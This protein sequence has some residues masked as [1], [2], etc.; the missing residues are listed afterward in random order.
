MGSHKNSEVIVPNYIMQI[1]L[2]NSVRTVVAINITEEICMRPVDYYEWCFFYLLFLGTIHFLVKEEC[3][4]IRA[5]DIIE[6]L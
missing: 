2:N 3:D 4:Y 5:I 6:I 1:I